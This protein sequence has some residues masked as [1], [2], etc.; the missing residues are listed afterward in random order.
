MSSMAL[1]PNSARPAQ[2]AAGNAYVTGNTF[3]DQTN[4]F[5]TTQ[6]SFQPVA[7][8]GGRDAFVTK[9]NATGNALVYSTFLGG[10]SSDQGEGIAVDSAGNAYVIGKTD[11]TSF[12]LEGAHQTTNLGGS[13]FVTKLNP[14]G[15]ALLYSSYLGKQV[16]IRT[17]NSPGAAIAVDAAGIAY[18]TGSTSAP[19]FPLVNPLFS[20]FSGVRDAYVAKINTVTKAVVYTT[21]L[22]GGGTDNGFGIAIDSAGNAYVTG[23][24]DSTNFPTKNPAQAT[25]GGSGDVFVAKISDD[26]I[27]PSVLRSGG[28]GL[29]ESC[30][31]LRIN[32][33]ADI[34]ASDPVMVDV[35]AVKADGT[36]DT[37]F[38]GTVQ[39]SLAADSTLKIGCL[40]S[41]GQCGT[42]QSLTLE[43]GK[44]KQPLSLVTPLLQPAGTELTTSSVIN[45]KDTV[46]EGKAVI[47]ATAG[48]LSA[49][50]E[51]KVSSPLDLKVNRMEVQQGVKQNAADLWIGERDV[52]VRVY[53]DAN[54][55][56]ANNFDKYSQIQGITAKLTVRDKS[57]NEIIGSP[58]TLSKGGIH[59][60]YLPG[61]GSFN[62][63][64]ADYVFR[65]N[66]GPAADGS[67]S[68]NYLLPG[69]FDSQWSLEV[70]LDDALPDRDASNNTA[71]YGPLNFANTRTQTFYYAK[72]RVLADNVKTEF[73]TQEGIDQEME[74]IKQSWPVGPRALKFVEQPDITATENPVAGEPFSLL[75]RLLGVGFWLSSGRG[76]R[77]VYFVDRDYFPQIRGRDFV[78]LWG[79]RGTNGITNPILKMSIVDSNRCANIP[80]KCGV[81]AHELGHQ[82]GLKD[83]YVLS[84][85]SQKDGNPVEA[86]NFTWFNHEFVGGT[87]VFGFPSTYLDF[88]GNGGDDADSVRTWVDL[89]TW[90]FLKPKLLF[91]SSQLQS[92]LEA[93]N[94]T[95]SFVV[96]Q[97]Q[98]SKNGTASF[99]NCYTLTLTDPENTLTPGDYVLETVDANAAVLSSL[100]FA[101][102]FRLPHAEQEVEK[103]GFNFALPF[104]SAVRQLRVRLG[105]TVLATRTVSANAP[106]VNFVSDLGGQTLTGTQQV[107][108][109][110]ADAD[111]NTLTYSLYY[112]PD[113]QLHL[114]LTETTATSYTWK[115]DGYL[116]GSAPRLTLVATDGINATVAESRTFTMPNRSPRITILSPGNLY[117]FKVG[118]PVVLTGSFF[119][120]EEDLQLNPPLQWMSNLQGPLGSGKQIAVSNLQAGTHLITVSGADSQGARG[121]ASITVVVR[122]DN[123]SQLAVTPGNIDFGT[124]AIGLARD[125]TLRVQNT[126]TAPATV[127]SISSDNPQFRV[128]A[129]AAPVALAAHAQQDVILRF[130]PIA[131][132]AQSGTLT[133]TCTATNQTSLSVALAGN[134][135]GSAAGT[136]TT[137][138]AASYKG[139]E[140]AAESIVAAFGS[141]MATS[142]AVA[143][144]VPLPTTLAGTTVRVRD[145]AGGERL[146]PLFFVA[147][148]QVNYLIPP[149]TAAG[150][151][152]VTITS[153]VGAVSVGAVTITPVAAGLFAANSDGQGPPAAYAVRVKA[154]GTQ[155]NELITR[156]DP[157]QNKFVLTPLD[158][159]PPGEQV[160]LVLFG[161]GFRAVSSLSAVS[162]QIGGVEAQVLYA[163]T[164]GGFVGLDQMNLLVPRSLIGRGEVELIV[165]INGTAA[166]TLKLNL[167]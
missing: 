146:A 167:K 112:S 53:L 121:T 10:N 137:V 36:I 15:S 147:P 52:M 163:G 149:G 66:A 22:G 9:L 129:P 154:D 41:G 143:S 101:P 123:F 122:P 113:G 38:N 119:D 95:G 128:L 94:V 139:L 90:N 63:P 134:A 155:S 50:S 74:F 54:R 86:G 104:S 32:A 156:F 135:I 100:N 39:V 83:T 152:T 140:L 133:I 62:A 34:F 69:T 125:I 55:T 165:T 12:P 105:N 151:A 29:E 138:S 87:P 18:V 166:N 25:P 150:A 89:F 91:T 98:V 56:G 114:P 85:A 8:G 160:V 81:L 118:D 64:D 28:S 96:A 33:K 48:N 162:V 92:P 77:Y 148:Q 110:G 88:M 16:W 20:T 24:T 19:D 14:S 136:A 47:K 120:P 145:S 37:S 72:L 97:G 43:S 68:L 73:P 31:A 21:F 30:L 17:G 6:G 27:C 23:Q 141:E 126:G 142:V 158:L 42:S 59:G 13:A 75:N 131:A 99:G 46:L 106:A 71:R 109:T 127:N 49:T 93:R 1:S 116:S 57:G 117:Q 157:A 58:F 4:N 80:I 76:L 103:F 79:D 102:D 70:K 82:L 3:G 40:R 124:L 108:W 7:P 115:T 164:Q 144:S 78:P 159:G 44:L 130:T 35:T 51:V 84:G 61:V 60:S 11:S 67:D 107:T 65:P 132:N 153:G 2:N 5:P 161:T 111:G 26:A 45:L